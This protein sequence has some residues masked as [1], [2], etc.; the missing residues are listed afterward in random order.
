MI[1]FTSRFARTYADARRKFRLAADL[2][3]VAVRSYRHPMMT[4]DGEETATDVALLG[5]PDAKAVMVMTAGVHGPELYCGSGAQVDAL[6]DLDLSRFDGV[7]ILMVHAVNP[8]GSAWIRR[9]NEDNIDINRN[10]VDFTKPRP[11]NPGYDLLADDLVPADLAPATLAAADARLAAWRLE[12][13]EAAFRVAVSGGQWTH[14][15]GMFYGG[16]APCWSRRTLE[17]IL[18]DYRLRERALVAVL[19]F[20][21]GAGPFGYCEPIFAG[22]PAHPGCARMR[23]WIGPGMT[24]QRSGK[25]ATPPQEGLNSELWEK[26]CGANAAYIGFEYGAMPGDEVLAALRAEYVF[27]RRGRNDW[28]DGEVQAVK[29]RL[30]DAF[31]P[32]SAEW[33]ELVLL[34][35]RPLIER[36]GRGLATEVAS[37]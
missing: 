20:H 23:R 17:A 18:D 37:A 30:L 33:R 6:L 34:Q 4:P 1:D 12:H 3:G 32:D 21:T 26:D 25:A 9:T 11:S 5:A 14:P 24:L 27:N 7:A 8:Y 2:R 35:A 16:T 31:C 15:T 10:F 13:G 36:V 29:R 22:D 19:D 28:H